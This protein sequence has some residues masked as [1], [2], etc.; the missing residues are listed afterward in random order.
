[1]NSNTN[2]SAIHFLKVKTKKVPNYVKQMFHGFH[3][4]YVK[5]SEIIASS[6]ELNNAGYFHNYIIAILKK[7]KITLIN[8]SN[9]INIVSILNKAKL[10]SWVSSIM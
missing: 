9:L 7:L 2:F 1:M 6:I 8:L 10:M 5:S 4:S 3:A